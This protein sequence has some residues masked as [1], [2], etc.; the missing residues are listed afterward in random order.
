MAKFEKNPPKKLA[1][2]I[3]DGFGEGAHDRGDAI[4]HAR[5]PFLRT[6]FLSKKFPTSHLKTFGSAV[7]LPE[8]QTGGSEAG[9]LTLGAG[10]P[11][12][13]F[14]TEINDQIESGEFFKNSTLRDLFFR[15]KKCG[16]IHLLGLASDGGIHSFLPHLFGLQK[17]AKKFEIPEIFIHPIL[18]GRDVGERTASGFLE[19][20]ESQK[21]G[22]IASV[23]GRF[24]GM[25]RDQ[26]WDR[27]DQHFAV[28][29]DK[30]TEISTDSWKK[31]LENFYKNSEK[32]DYYFPPILFEKNGQIRP[33]DVVIFFNFRA[34]RAR[35][36]SARILER[37][38]EKN[39]GV[40]GKYGENARKIFAST[41]PE[42]KNTL[43]EVVSRAGFRQLR[44]S[45][46]EKFN[47]VTFYFSGLRKIEF[48]G[49]TRILVPSPKCPSYAEKPEMSAREQTDA[50]IEAIEKN[51]FAL[52]VQNFANADLVGHSGDLTATIEAIEVLDE[53]LARLVPKFL[54]K[55][56]EILITADHGNADEM[57][58]PAGGPNASHT[59]NPVLCV[60]ISNAENH[61]K[62]RENGALADVAPT[63]LE[64]LGIGKPDEMTGESLIC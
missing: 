62:F 42:I 18:D 24:F 4:F 20:I 44:V 3:L 50:V 46:T 13:Q 49:E 23:G 52:I 57:L 12:R 35:Q 5:T 26:N 9:H 25:D 61:G 54:E 1:L 45:E 63:I 14:L 15:A 64:I 60:W 22:K 37:V 59:K 47:H 29:A 10:R 21:I 28:L 43:G 34:D 30:K 55:N 16:R 11:V 33:E 40:F 17:M 38:G 58:T 6:N 19:Q 41:T 32:S 51:D 53:C 31:N 36:I 39:F 27:I 8:F 56:Y 48:P 7:G 2:V